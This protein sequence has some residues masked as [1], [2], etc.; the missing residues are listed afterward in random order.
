MPF[1]FPIAVFASTRLL[2][3]ERTPIPKS[4]AVPVEYPLPLVSFH[5]NELLDPCTHMPPHGLVAC[6]FRTATFP[7]TLISEDVGLT[8]IPDMQFVVVVTP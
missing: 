6:P 4:V 3:P 5:R 1:V 7:S 8:R 2:L